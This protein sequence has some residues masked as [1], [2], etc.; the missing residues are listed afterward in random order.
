MNSE[1]RI[2]K[3]E[4]QVAELLAWKQQRMRQQLTFPLDKTSKDILSKDLVVWTGVIAEAPPNTGA[5]CT[6]N[7]KAWGFY[8]DDPSVFS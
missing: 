1:E 2:K 5:I 6:L 8:I 7:G 3:L 4:A